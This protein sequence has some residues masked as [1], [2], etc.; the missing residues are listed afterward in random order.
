MFLFFL[1]SYTFL[2]TFWNTPVKMNR[3]MTETEGR[4]NG[5]IIVLKQ[6][7]QQELARLCK[8]T[9]TTVNNAIHHNARGVKAEKVRQ[10]FKIK[11]GSQSNG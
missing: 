6:G 11:Y 2:P 10:M 3:K 4:T 5:R 1:Q 8:C 9:P 7:W